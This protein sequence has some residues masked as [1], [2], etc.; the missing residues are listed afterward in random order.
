MKSI[1]MHPFLP[2]NL[3]L[4]WDIKARPNLSYFNLVKV[5]HVHLG[6]KVKTILCR[7]LW[8]RPTH[9]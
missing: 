7:T 4:E 1:M 5:D 2:F 3:G 9:R 6:Y 8:H